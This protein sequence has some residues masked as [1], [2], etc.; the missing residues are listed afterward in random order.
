M[1]STWMSQ[2][3]KRTKKAV[4]CKQRHPM[5]ME[6]QRGGNLYFKSGKDACMS[7]NLKV[8][9]IFVDFLQENPQWSP[10]RLWTERII[11]LIITKNHRFRSW[12]E[13]RMRWTLPVGKSQ[14][15]EEI[16]HV[17]KM[18]LQV[19]PGIRKCQVCQP[20]LVKTSPAKSFLQVSHIFPS[21]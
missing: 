10:A 16:N 12:N 9:H 17:I 19:N 15:N 18:S 3:I 6:H 14:R 2:C 4:E 8:L 13:K 21:G 5:T 20:Y 7:S 11:E 1:A